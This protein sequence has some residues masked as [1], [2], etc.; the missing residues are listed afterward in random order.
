MQRTNPKQWGIFYMLTPIRDMGPLFIVP[1][2][3]LGRGYLAI[4]KVLAHNTWR[5]STLHL[6]LIRF[7]AGQSHASLATRNDSCKWLLSDG[8][9]AGYNTW[10]PYGCMMHTYTTTD[11][12]R[13]MHYINYWGGQ[14]HITFLGDSRIRQLYYEFVNMLSKKKIEEEKVHGDLHF[15][16][17][18]IR[19]KVD[20]L[21]HPM[22]NTSMYYVYKSWLMLETNARPNLVITGSGTWS[23]KLNN[24]SEEAIKNFE[25]PVDQSKLSPNRS[26]ITNYQVDQYNKV[27]LNTLS[28]TEARIWSSSRLIAQGI[29]GGDSLDGLHISKPALTLDIMMLL[30]MYC[31]DHMNYNDGTCCRIP[32]G[33]TTLQIITAAFFLVCMLSALALFIYRRRL[34]RNGSKARAENGQRNGTKEKETCEVWYEIMS[35]LFKLGIIM[36]YFFL[37]D[38]T[39][40]FMKENKYYTHVNFFLP[41]A[42]VMILGFFFTE[43]TEQTAVLHRDQTDE[44]KGWMQ[45]V[46]LIYHLTGASKVLPIYM[47]IRVMVSTYLF[48]TGYGHFSYFWKKG[49]YSLYRYCQVMFRL[50]FLVIVLCFVM[51]RPYQFYYFV[52]LVSFWFM[53][54]YVTMAI[55]PRISMASTEAN[56]L[57]YFYLILKF[58]LLGT[59][60]ALFY[61]SEVFFEKVFLTRPI[62]SLFVTSDDSLHE[63]RFRWELD[64]YSVLYGMILAFGYQFLVKKGIIRDSTGDSLFSTGMSWLLMAVGLI[65][66]GS[67]STFALLCE[68]KTECNRV[69]SYLVAV[70]IVSFILVRNIFGWIRTRY[71]SFFAWFGRISLEVKIF[72]FYFIVGNPRHLL[73]YTT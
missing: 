43:S 47:H 26:M 37:C 22:V 36:A 33:A 18:K 15:E 45:L 39:N 62:K 30:N 69:H 42:Y 67:Y 17:K 56:S 49:D 52:P 40:F 9:F 58:V 10:Q 38:R 60:I 41:F 3:R 66:V 35:S 72:N 32:D 44:W 20:F 70:P 25:D 24:A 53:I 61:L 51:N 31:N 29:R 19:V 12:R 57:H 1:S 68:N 14:N 64:R 27:A 11:A 73:R 50:N 46:I 23:I 63:W 4:Y 8:R 59:A 55:W 65:G 7:D 48:L 71:S 5:G 28:D 16:D 2:E 6:V 13:C 54:V 34:R 21:W